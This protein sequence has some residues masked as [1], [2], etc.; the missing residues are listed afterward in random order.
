ETAG[1]DEVFL[2]FQELTAL[3]NKANFKAFCVAKN[4]PTLPFQTKRIEIPGEYIV[5]PYLGSGSL[6][7]YRKHFLTGEAVAEGHYAEQIA[8]G[9]TFGAGIVYASGRVVD[10]LVWQRIR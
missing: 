9:R 7:I 4:L 3:D 1:T 8:S 5:K 2:D 6:G 10:L